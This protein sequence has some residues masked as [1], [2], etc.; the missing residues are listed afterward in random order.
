M[1][2]KA[3]LLLIGAIFLEISLLSISSPL[4]GDVSAEEETTFAFKTGYPDDNIDWNME[5]TFTFNTGYRSDDL[6][7]NIAGNIYGNNPNILSELSWSDLN[8]HQIKA[9][10]KV[11]VNETFYLRCSLGYGWIFDGK[12]QDSDYSGDNRTFEFSRSNNDADDGNVLDVSLGVGYQFGQVSGMVIIT[13]L[14]G[15]SYHEQKLRMTDGFQTIGVTTGPFAGLNS[16]YETEWNGPWIGVDLSFEINKKFTLFGAFEYHMADYYAKANWNLRTDFAHP[17]SFEH[18]ADGSGIVMSIGGDYA[19]NDQWFINVNIDYQDWS[20]Y[21]GTD[22]IFFANG[23][24]SETR[25]NE[26]NWDSFAGML[27]LTYRF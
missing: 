21:A 9:G 2:K 5:T 11:I 24:T 23:T 17:K 6:D 22:R 20:T 14:V 13:P 8:I 3:W 18:T 1:K 7:W 16:T 19:L 10:G 25:L 4:I 12:N 15:Y 27:G 26:V